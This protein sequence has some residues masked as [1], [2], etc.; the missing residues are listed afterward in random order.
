MPT[1]KTVISCILLGVILLSGCG[2]NN[3]SPAITTTSTSTDAYLQSYQ[4][5]IVA[6]AKN[7]T[8]FRKVL[9][10]G[11]HSQLVLM[12]I[13]P[14]TEIGDEVHKVA[15]QTLIFVSG[16]G[17]AI[18]N[19]VTTSITAGDVAV[20]TP[21]TEHNF[22]NTGRVPL[23]LY[24]IYAPPNHIA[25]TTEKTKADADANV[26]DEAYGNQVTVK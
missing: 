22:I 7:N 1:K 4:T 10:T 5:N 25:G 11:T 16:S 17:E 12:S 24:T 3:T 8:D 2:K 14:G 15:E 26:A 20:V 18:L 23:Q 21:G 9:F 19:G 13:P 6:E